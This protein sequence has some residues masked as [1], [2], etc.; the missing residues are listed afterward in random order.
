MIRTVTVLINGWRSLCTDRLAW[1][2]TNRKNVR[3]YSVWKRPTIPRETCLLTSKIC[4]TVRAITTL[5]SRY[6]ILNSSNEVFKILKNW[7][8]NCFFQACDQ[9]DNIEGVQCSKNETYRICVVDVNNNNPQF[10]FPESNDT[11]FEVPEN[12]PVGSP[13]IYNGTNLQ[14]TFKATDKDEWLNGQITYTWSGK[15]IIQYFWGFVIF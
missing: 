3:N 11:V 6:Y 2:L 1:E 8:K 7:F 14:L 9:G 12:S 15:V 10:V 4:S 13:L 5:S